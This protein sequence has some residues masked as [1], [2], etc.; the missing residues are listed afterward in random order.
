MSHHVPYLSQE[1]T[2]HMS[3]GVPHLSQDV[4]LKSHDVPYLS[5]DIRVWMAEKLVYD[6]GVVQESAQAHQHCLV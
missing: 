1:D 3:Q 5:H 4:T 2:P 6:P